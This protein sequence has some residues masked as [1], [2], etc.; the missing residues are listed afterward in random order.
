VILLLVEG[1]WRLRDCGAIVGCDDG[2]GVVVVV[3]DEG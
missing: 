3:V 1:M 2:G